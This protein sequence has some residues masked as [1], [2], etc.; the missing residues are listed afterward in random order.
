[1]FGTKLGFIDEGRDVDG[2]LSAFRSSVWFLGLM[3]LFPYILSPIVK[4]PL[5]KRFTLPTSEGK[6]GVGRIMKVS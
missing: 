1:M 6:R 4:C 5:I 3:A 2:L